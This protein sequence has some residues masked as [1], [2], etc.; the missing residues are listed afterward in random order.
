MF[1]KVNEEILMEEEVITETQ[2]AKVRTHYCFYSK[3]TLT[4]ENNAVVNSPI[5]ITAK[6]E[7]WQGE[8]IPEENRDIK[9]TITGP[10]E[11]AEAILTPVNGQAEFDFVSPVEGTF[12]IR[13]KANFACDSAEMEVLVNA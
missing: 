2:T 12:K 10:A 7:T 4:G 11:P 5:T 9:I 3:I 1:I 13:A 8:L 6:Y